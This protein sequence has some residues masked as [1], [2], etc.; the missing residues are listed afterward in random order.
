MGRP[1]TISR[2]DLLAA[3]EAV[4]LEH[5]AARLTL[6]AVAARAGVSKGGLLYSYPTKEALLEGMIERR[7]A[8]ARAVHEEVL[9]A[10]PPGAGRA[11]DAYVTAS[12]EVVGSDP[13]S[14]A[15]LA[16]VAHDTRLLAPLRGWY[17]ASL[18]EITA[19]GVPYERAA[20][21][22]LATEG[23]WIME[24]L[25]IAPFNAAERARVVAELHRAA[26]GPPRVRRQAARA[27]HPA[28]RR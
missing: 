27:R 17:R 21:V 12:T 18:E 11:L 25:G 10:A 13:V 9:A 2:D 7:I 20:A 8:R 3:A 28:R 15:L 14:A 23:L 24:L 4:V 19:G 16:A 6:D 22:L 5:G 26:G 1:A